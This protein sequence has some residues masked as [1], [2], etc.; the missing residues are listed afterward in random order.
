MSRF[1]DG[2]DLIVFANALIEDLDW[3]EDDANRFEAA[4][5]ELGA[6][7]GLGSQRPEV[8]IG[9]GPDNLWALGRSSFP[10]Y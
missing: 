9:K 10:F 4:I 6:L 2:N 3:Y 5:R 7:L 1:L 8:E